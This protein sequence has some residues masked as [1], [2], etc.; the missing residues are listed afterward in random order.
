M[1]QQALGVTITFRSRKQSVPQ[2]DHLSTS[3]QQSDVSE[4]RIEMH[5]DKGFRLEI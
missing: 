2:E 3:P 5:R 1:D 4:D